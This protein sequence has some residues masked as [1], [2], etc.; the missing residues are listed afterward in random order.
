MGHMVW[1]IYTECDMVSPT[2]RLPTKASQGTLY[3]VGC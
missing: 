1:Y 3:C 2:V